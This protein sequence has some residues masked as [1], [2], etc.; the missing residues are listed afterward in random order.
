VIACGKIWTRAEA[1]AVLEQ[2][3]DLIALGRAAILNPDWPKQVAT[4]AGEAT[5]KV[6]PITEAE[7]YERAVSPLFAGYL[8]R[9]KNLVAE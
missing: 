6:P 9:W 8:T 7:L 2:G 4:P 3:A 5:I 1:E